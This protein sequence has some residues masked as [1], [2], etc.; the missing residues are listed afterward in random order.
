MR[1]PQTANEASLKLTLSRVAVLLVV[2]RV[3]ADRA[4][5]VNVVHEVVAQAAT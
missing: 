5:T 4:A 1:N 2:G 3:A